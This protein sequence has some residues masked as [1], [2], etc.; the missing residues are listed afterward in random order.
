MGIRMSYI[1]S[2]SNPRSPTMRVGNVLKIFIRLKAQEIKSLGV[3]SWDMVRGGLIVMCAGGLVAFIFLLI[4]YGLGHLW[5]W[6]G[7]FAF[8]GDTNQYMNCGFIMFFGL[9]CLAL[10]GL[11]AYQFL[12]WIGSN[13]QTAK[14]IDA[15]DETKGQHNKETQK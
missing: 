6:I 11:V 10:I 15:Q 5:E 13:W 2:T 3:D 8:N 7:G 12:K 1:R 9:C 4:I 14:Q